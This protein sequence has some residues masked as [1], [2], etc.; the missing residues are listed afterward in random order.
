MPKEPEVKKEVP[1]LEQKSTK[2]EENKKT[3]DNDLEVWFPPLEFIETIHGERIAIP[4]I[5]SGREIKVFQAIARL[6]EA[7]PKDKIKNLEDFSAAD[8]FDI[9]PNLLKEAPKEGLLIA[10]TIL[11]SKEHSIDNQ[12]VEDNLDLEKI[13]SL[14]IPFV[15][16]EADL[17]GKVSSLF[18]KLSPLGKL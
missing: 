1:K 8:L 18:A 11:N 5:S 3:E 9:L 7:L 10:S 12:W 14:I 13:F 17:F 15:S 6:L 16:R 2:E 4:P